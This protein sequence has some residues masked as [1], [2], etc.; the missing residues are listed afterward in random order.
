MKDNKLKMKLWKKITLGV[1]CSLLGLIIVLTITIFSVWHNEINSISSIKLLAEKDDEQNSAPVYSIDIKG[2]Y[3]FE[4]FL[5]QGG[6]SSDNEL[7]NFIVK[8]ITKG[9]IPINIG[10]SDIGCSSFTAKTKAG[11]QL[12]G[13]NYDFDRTTSLI[14]HTKPSDGRFE[15][16]SSVDVQFLGLKDGTYIDGLMNQFLTLAAPYAPL[17]GINEKGVA[18]GIY[19][20]YQGT[21]L[22][23]DGSIRYVATDQQTDKPDITSTTLLRLILDKADSVNKA[24]ELA[25]QY[26]MHDSANTSFHYMVSDS[27]GA[28]AIFEYVPEGGNYLNDN[29]GTKRVLKVYKN[30]DD[31]ILGE[32]EG[33]NSFQYITNFLVTPG[34]YADDSEKHGL[35][36]YNKIEEMINPSSTNTAGIVEDDNYALSILETVG[37]RKW[38]KANGNSDANGKTIWSVLYDLTAKKMTWVNN[39]KFGDKDNVFSFNL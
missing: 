39:E 8:N 10:L 24:I 17:D 9:I 37:R 35:D 7:I 4:K 5:K 29:D 19:M 38:D 20:S 21:K 1:I 22:S 31:I 30:D 15:S 16:Y 28:S 36:R 27:T 18:C 14:V 11:S 34:Y 13:R 23:S 33:K 12:F 6:A 32:K 25:K 2:N 26:D 3:Y